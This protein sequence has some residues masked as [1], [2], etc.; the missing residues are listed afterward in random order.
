MSNSH[1]DPAFAA[2]RLPYTDGPS[3]TGLDVGNLSATPLRQ[4]RAWYEEARA[5][6]V[7]EPNAMTLATVDADG[8]PTARTVLLKNADERGFTLFTNY[9]SRKGGELAA[10]PV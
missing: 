9:S 4:F 8:A 3:A 2:Q 10:R 6:G 5:A 7:T 1:I